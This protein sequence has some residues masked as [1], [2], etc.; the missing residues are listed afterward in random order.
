MIRVQRA[1][2]PDE[3]EQVGHLLQIGWH[4]RVVASEMHVVED[5]VDDV[6][7]VP[8]TRIQLATA[9]FSTTFPLLLSGRDRAGRRDGENY[10]C[11]GHGTQSTS[12]SSHRVPP[13]STGR[14]EEVD[15]AALSRGILKSSDDVEI[16]DG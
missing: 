1:V 7:D 16:T 2:V 9:C 8:L 13:W 6:L 10:R 11:Q 14:V 3:V 15:E 12:P 4:V 5:D